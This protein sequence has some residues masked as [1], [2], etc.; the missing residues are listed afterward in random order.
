MLIAPSFLPDTQ[1]CKY[2][3]LQHL[4]TS[5]ASSVATPAPLLSTPHSASVRQL[6]SLL[7]ILPAMATSCALPHCPLVPRKSQFRTSD[8]FR[9]KTLQH[10]VHRANRT[11]S[12]YLFT[13]KF[14]FI[15]MCVC[16]L[17]CMCNH[18]HEVDCG[19]QKRGLETGVT[20]SCREPQD[21]GSKESTLGL[22]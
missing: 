21:V 2:Q 3:L 1:I 8:S 18:M 13:L 9:S 14:K 20:G 19:D 16:L 10:S 6:D 22:M 7:L 12:F 4:P 15:C 17:V 11:V 5:A